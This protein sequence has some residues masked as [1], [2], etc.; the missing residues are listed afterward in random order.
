MESQLYNSRDRRKGGRGQRGQRGQRREQGRGGY[1]R[2]RGRGGEGGRCRGGGG[3]SGR[4][5]GSHGRDGR[6]GGGGGSRGSGRG[7]SGRGGQ[8]G[9]RGSRGRGDR[10]ASDGAWRPPGMV[11][12]RRDNQDGQQSQRQNGRLSQPVA[13]NTT[14]SFCGLEQQIYSA[15]VGT[16]T[17]MCPEQERQERQRN[18]QL[19]PF[20]TEAS[21]T[22]SRQDRHGDQISIPSSTS[23]LAVKE[24]KR[25]SA[26]HEMASP[27]DLRTPQALLATMHYLCDHILASKSMRVPTY[28]FL[29]NRIRAVRQDITVQQLQCATTYDVLAMAVRFHSL[30]AYKLC[31]DK[32]F[33]ANL[34]NMQLKECLEVGVQR[35]VFWCCMACNHCLQTFPATTCSHLQPPAATC[36]HR[37][38]QATTGNHRQPLATTTRLLGLHTNPTDQASVSKC[39]CTRCNLM[40]RRHTCSGVR[41]C[42]HFFFDT[43]PCAGLAAFACVVFHSRCLELQI[44]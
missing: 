14:A 10:A 4:H 3:Q 44:P 18:E 41:A 33:D 16:C 22:V 27:A 42:C 37:Q 39:Q 8:V 30:A 19:H 26:G 31:H 21:S 17:T 35:S 11:P 15:P 6:G 2:G 29:W 12:A 25:P 32:A 1:G 7:Y 23:A 20:E 36:N 38:P 24:Y 40:G 9:A 34:N 13:P 28:M 43:A 5:D